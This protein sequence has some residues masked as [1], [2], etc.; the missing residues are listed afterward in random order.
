MQTELLFAGATSF[1]VTILSM[2]LATSSPASAVTPVTPTKV[3]AAGIPGHVNNYCY[4]VRNVLSQR[5]Y[6]KSFISGMLGNAWQE[7]MCMSKTYQRNQLGMLGWSGTRANNLTKFARQH[8]TKVDNPTLQALFIDYEILNLF[9]SIIKIF[10]FSL[11]INSS[12]DPKYQI[13]S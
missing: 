12:L 10:H 1:V 9:S 8:N 2:G 6:S 3:V 5:G 11:D 13:F 4:V 7:S